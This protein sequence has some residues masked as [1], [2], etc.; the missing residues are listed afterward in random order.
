[1]TDDSSHP[2]PCLYH[3]QLLSLAL[4]IFLSLALYLLTIALSATLYCY[5]S[6][7]VKLIYPSPPKRS[8]Y[9]PTRVERGLPER[10]SSQLQYRTSAAPD[11][12]EKSK[13]NTNV[14]VSEPFATHTPT[15]TPAL[16]RPTRS[17]ETI[18]DSTLE[19]GMKRSRRGIGLSEDLTARNLDMLLDAVPLPFDFSLARRHLASREKG[20][21]DEQS[22]ENSLWWYHPI[23]EA[24]AKADIRRTL[25]RIQHVPAGHCG[26]PTPISP[27]LQH[28]R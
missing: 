2:F 14:K 6:Y 10:D 20:E 4:H 22:E 9:K 28:S 21:N 15:P 19:Y 17:L 3:C 27:S 25:S 23:F 8:T 18:P 5:F 13:K 24:R 7:Q 26:Q 12:V 1:M 16:A 11:H